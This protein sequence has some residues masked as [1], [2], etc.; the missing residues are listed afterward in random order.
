MP[1]D[2]P[3][4]RPPVIANSGLNV[5]FG[6][7]AFGARPKLVSPEL[8]RSAACLGR[9]SSLRSPSAPTLIELSAYNHPVLRPWR[10]ARCAPRGSLRAAPVSVARL[11]VSEL[12]T[13]PL[14][15]RWCSARCAPFGALHAATRQTCSS[16]RRRGTP[17]RPSNRRRGAQMN[18]RTLAWGR[19]DLNADASDPCVAHSDLCAGRSDC[20]A[21]GIGRGGDTVGPACKAQRT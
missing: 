2:P 18:D 17:S 1:A 9:C 20:R 14:F 11:F 5:D 21:D 6:R 4:P 10:S 8:A 13:S 7:D 3:A 19:P 15:R 16:S 12:P